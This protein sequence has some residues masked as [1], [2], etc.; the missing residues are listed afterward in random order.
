MTAVVIRD[1]VHGDIA[2]TDAEKRVLDTRDMQRLRGIK[3]TGTAYLVYPGCVHTRF[4]HSLGTCGVAKRIIDGLRRVGYN[5]HRDDEELVSVAALVHDTTHIPFGHTFEDERRIFPRHDSGRRIKAFL[6]DGEIGTVLKSLGLDQE[7]LRI[8]SS[9]DPVSEGYPAPWKVQ[10][11]SG[12]VD[13]D[14]L[15]YL[16]RDSYFS[17]LAQNYDD[18][19]F[20]YFALEDGQLVVSMSKHG[21]DRPDA[22]SEVLHLLRMRYFLTERIYT[23]HAKISSGAMIS[24]AVELACRYGLEE[25]RLYPL[26][27]ATFL[28]FLKRFP[29]EAPDPVLGHLVT[30]VEERKLLKRAYVLSSARIGRSKRDSLIARYSSSVVERDELETEVASA[31]DLEPGEVIVHCPPASFFKEI[32]V[33]V[34]TGE[35]ISR[36]TALAPDHS[37]DVEALANQY[38]DL[39]KFYVFIPAGRTG[40]TERAGEACQALIGEPNEY[41]PGLR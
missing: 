4:D 31:L 24:R 40:L 39:W 22:R 2:L 27:D 12:C 5:I 20:S 33:P 29:P 26:T 35:G 9:R 17:G 38:E 1:P 32:Q 7:V 23:H 8:L 19:I 41:C 14:L 11:V 30:S 3:Q 25:D 21:M 18:R 37:K 6:V 10:I 15:D 34:R 36:L 13:A 28:E 16:R